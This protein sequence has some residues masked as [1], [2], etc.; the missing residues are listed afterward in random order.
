MSDVHNTKKNSVQKNRTH[1]RRRF[2][3]TSIIGG[4][5][6]LALPGNVLFGQQAPSDKLNI[7]MIAAGGRARAH[8]GAAKGEN[9]VAICDIN[10]KTLGQAIRT[11]PRAKQYVD[12][13]KC[14]DHKGLDAVIC[15]TTDHTHA[16]V[17]TWAMN[18]D[19]HVYCEKPQ[20]ICVA[21]ARMM[22]SKYLEK[23]NKIATQLGTQRHAIPNFNRVR[24][25]VLDGAVGTLKHVHAWG[26]RQIRRKGYLEKKGEPPP[27]LYYDLWVGP[28]PMHPYN[29]G[30]LRGCL[31]WNMYWDFGTGQIGDMGSHTMDLAWHAIDAGLPTSAK[32]HGEPFNPEVTPVDFTATFEHPANDW[33]PPITVTWYQGAHKPSSIEGVKTNYG[34]GALFIG[35]KGFVVSGFSN[36]RIEPRDKAAG[37]KHYTP[38]SKEKQIPSIGGFQ[39]QWVKACKTD[40]KTSCDFDYS[41]T[42][43]EQMLLG[44]VAYR[45]GKKITYDGKKGRVTNSDEANKLLSRTYRKG[46][47][48]DG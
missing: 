4:A 30:Y 7:A 18:R 24:E 13:R 37:M 39:Q 23:K 40:L 6:L 47:K 27:G 42:A 15:S 44:L 35:D 28:S 25:A 43:S 32:A 26:D 16:F 17:A 33:R 1:S 10:E 14:V 29:P 48:L 41:G 9:V 5:G 8:F 20:G 38:R 46:W 12:W 22:R 21:E 45:V 34:H 31:A 3:K 2:M 19:L 36:H 11:F